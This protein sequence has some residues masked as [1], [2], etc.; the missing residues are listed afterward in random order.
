[1]ST[2]AVARSGGRSSHFEPSDLFLLIPTGC[3]T[4]TGS[5]AN[6]TEALSLTV[7]VDD[8]G[9]VLK[10]AGYGTPVRMRGITSSPLPDA[11][12]A[13]HLVIVGNYTNAAANTVGVMTVQ[14]LPYTWVR[15]AC[16]NNYRNGQLVQFGTPLTEP[17]WPRP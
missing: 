11:N 15:W 5:V 16:C 7:T 13:L 3:A 6:G 17:V 2:R 14:T 4:C 12:G 1:L 9:Q 10:N 8:A